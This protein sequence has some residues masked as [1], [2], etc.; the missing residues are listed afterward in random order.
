MALLLIGIIRQNCHS[1]HSSTASFCWLTALYH[2]L[3]LLRL[4]LPFKEWIVYTAAIHHFIA[5]WQTLHKVVL[6]WLVKCIMLVV[7]YQWCHTF[8]GG[9]VKPSL[10]GALH[11][12]GHIIY[13]Y[14]I[15][16]LITSF[17][18]W[19]T[20]LA[21]LSLHKCKWIYNAFPHLP[22]LTLMPFLCLAFEFV[23]VLDD[24]SPK[25]YMNKNLM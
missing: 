2:E 17:L 1:R 20:S 18:M 8:R 13:C 16:S 3:C 14:L 15:K 23:H 5:A 4:L 24:Y 25:S 12:V 19:M 21:L 7:N 10:F 11:Y 22:P 6:I 9:V